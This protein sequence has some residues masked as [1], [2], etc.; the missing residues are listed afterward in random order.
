VVNR[1]NVSN[2]KIFLKPRKFCLHWANRLSYCWTF[3]NINQFSIY[4]R[5]D[6]EF[7]RLEISYPVLI[8]PKKSHM[9]KRSDGHKYCT[10]HSWIL[11][12]ESSSFF[13]D[14]P[15]FLRESDEFLK[16]WSLTKEKREAP[17][18]WRNSG[19]KLTPGLKSERQKKKVYN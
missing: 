3:L 13:N 5:K 4:Q 8:I 14:P 16:R 7:F 15:V 19:R 2:F 17:I 10:F 11:V 9:K 12:Q 1:R 6:E 18:V